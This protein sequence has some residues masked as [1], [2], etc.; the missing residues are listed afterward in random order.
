MRTCDSFGLCI[1]SMMIAGGCFVFFT[2]TLWYMVGVRCNLNPFSKTI[3]GDQMP[4]F[5]AVVPPAQTRRIIF[6]D[7][8]VSMEI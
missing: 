5:K 8:P 4:F 1:S 7:T 3:V 2:H 6:R